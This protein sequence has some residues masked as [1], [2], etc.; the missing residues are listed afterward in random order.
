MDGN[1]ARYNVYT[2]KQEREIG[3][4]SSTSLAA[5]SVRVTSGLWMSVCLSSQ[6]MEM[7]EE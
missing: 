3:K 6:H 5:L 4:C 7:E 1:Y 2:E